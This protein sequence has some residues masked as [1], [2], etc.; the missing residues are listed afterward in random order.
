MNLVNLLPSTP[1]NFGN[2]ILFICHLFI[3]GDFRTSNILFDPNLFDFNLITEFDNSNCSVWIPWTFIDLTKIE[4]LK[5]EPNYYFDEQ[6]LQ[7]I[8]IDMTDNNS[9]KSLNEFSSFYRLFIFISSKNESVLHLHSDKDS[10]LRFMDISNFSP[11]ILMYDQIMDRTSIY[12]RIENHLTQILN[13]RMD[14][15]LKNVFSKTFSQYDKKWQLTYLIVGNTSCHINEIKK[16]STQLQRDIFMSKL[17]IRTFNVVLEKYDVIFYKNNSNLMPTF[18][19]LIFKKIYGEFTRER[20][21][22]LEKNL[23]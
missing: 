19:R 8:F 22:P 7:L 6:T 10:M 9:I 1:S 20:E 5:E 14:H 11:L 23:V 16:H 13:Q 3:D 2:L 21:V 4:H 18:M 17:F 12:L 15:P